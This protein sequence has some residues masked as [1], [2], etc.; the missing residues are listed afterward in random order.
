MI[1]E[2]NGDFI[3]RSLDSFPQCGGNRLRAAFLLSSN[4]LFN[5]LLI[6]YNSRVGE[7]TGAR[8]RTDFRGLFSP[9]AA[10]TV[11]VNIP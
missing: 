6:A 2:N 5:S 3:Y 9:G 8:M 1:R 7:E 10:K 4:Q 11:G